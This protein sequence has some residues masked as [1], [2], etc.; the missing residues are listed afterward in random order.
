MIAEEI[1]YIEVQGF[2]R[3]VSDRTIGHNSTKGKFYKAAFIHGKHR[4]VSS[5]D[6]HGPWSINRKAL[7]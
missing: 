7:V 6:Y 2:G 3:C 4:Q 5:D 1:V